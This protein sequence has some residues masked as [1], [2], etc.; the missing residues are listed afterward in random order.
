M[1]FFLWNMAL[2]LIWALAWGFTPENVLIGFL[3]GYLLMSVTRRAFPPTSYFDKVGQL[4]RLVAL[5]VGDFVVANLQIARLVLTPRLRFQPGIVAVPLDT[6]SDLEITLVSN[7]LTLTP[8]SLSLE[9][10]PDRQVL[11]VHGMDVVDGQ[12]F[13]RKVKTTFEAPTLKVLR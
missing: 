13:V 5:F 12:D 9:V 4:A 6:R 11:Y 10:S 3:L 8:G 2:A 7:L 1:T